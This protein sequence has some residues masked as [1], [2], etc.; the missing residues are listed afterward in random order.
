MDYEEDDDNNPTKCPK[1]FP[2]CNG[3]VDNRCSA[4]FTICNSLGLLYDLE[5]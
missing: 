4:S 1:E 2:I 5:Y 3:E